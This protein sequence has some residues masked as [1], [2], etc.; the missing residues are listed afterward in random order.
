VPDSSGTPASPIREDF[1]VA[2][3]ARNCRSS[4]QHLDGFEQALAHACK[5]FR[6]MP[7]FHGLPDRG[8]GASKFPK[9]TSLAILDN[10]LVGG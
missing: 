8:T 10:H 5:G 6:I 9:L 7:R 2:T 3:Q 1:F 4:L